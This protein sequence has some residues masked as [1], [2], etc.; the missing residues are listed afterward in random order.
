MG[1]A[2]LQRCQSIKRV[3]QREVECP[4][5]GAVFSLCEPD[6]WKRLPGPRVCP[7]PGCCW[8]TTAEA[9]HDSWKHRDLLGTAA[10]QI[11]ETYLHN[12][13]RA[14]TT[15]ER[16]IRIDQLIHSFHISLRT[17][18]PGRSFANNLIE[19]SHDQVVEFLDRLSAKADGVDKDRWRAEVKGM[20][21]TRRGQ[22]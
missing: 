8:E 14:R 4:R 16:M 1:L 20:Y 2:L 11:F 17:G 10:V 5:C 15:K 12:Y 18:R 21:R 6:S 9:W 7:N 19:D 3:T 22:A 13:P